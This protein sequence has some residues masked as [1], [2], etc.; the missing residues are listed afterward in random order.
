MKKSTTILFIIFIIF[1]LL[2]TF[3]YIN[4]L[5]PF[6]DKNA[7]TMNI[8]ITCLNNYENQ[9]YILDNIEQL[10]KLGH[11]N[12]YIITNEH[13]FDGFNRFKDNIH[14]I[15]LESLENSYNIVANNDFLNLTSVRFFYIY[16]LMKKHNI[17]NVIH[18]ENDVL[19]YYNCDKLLEFLDKN[20]LYIPFDTIDRNVASIV[21]IPNHTIF[22]EILDHYDFNYTDMVN[23]YLISKKT[24]HIRHFP[25]FT[26]NIDDYINDNNI[27]T[28]EFYFVTENFDKFGNFIFDGAAIGQ[29][30]GT[31]W[32]NG[33]CNIKYDKY[34]FEW[35]D[36]ND[37]KIKRPFISIR[38]KLYPIFNL[39]IHC[40]QL[41][42]FM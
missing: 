13:L 18:L 31:G 30:L 7:N 35:D 33:D 16:E 15:S 26:N 5:E 32:V 42:R 40:K 4:H 34:S 24:D 8:V 17:E 37:D 1:I 11:T 3:F 25:I 41:R 36:N 21:Y 28:D 29:Y 9:I 39:H 38:G 14:L 19:I 22:K 2:L 12:I 6:E 23:F 20:K 27:S 10:I